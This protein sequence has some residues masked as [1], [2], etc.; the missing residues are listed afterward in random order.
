MRILFYVDN[1]PETMCQRQLQQLAHSNMPQATQSTILVLSLGF[2]FPQVT[3]NRIQALQD[4]GILILDQTK[5]L[6]QDNLIYQ[7]KS[8]KNIL[9]QVSNAEDCIVQ[10]NKLLTFKRK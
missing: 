2:S 7:G 1:R 8:K 10:N 5:G 9:Q 3:K 6:V 4:Y